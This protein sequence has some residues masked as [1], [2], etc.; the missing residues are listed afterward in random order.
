MS[1]MRDNTTTNSASP[2]ADHSSSLDLEQILKASRADTCQEP[3]PPLSQ[4]NESNQK[5]LWVWDH[6]Q[7]VEGME[8]KTRKFI[9]NIVDSWLIVQVN[10]VLLFWVTI[11]ID[12]KI[13]L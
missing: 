12:V 9:V 6:Y 11:F 8:K 13:S 4:K 2:N 10:M 7:I 3:R 5:K 1:N